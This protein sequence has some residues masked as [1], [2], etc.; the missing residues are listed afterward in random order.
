[1]VLEEAFEEVVEAMNLQESE[2]QL[3]C[4]LG[5]IEHMRRNKAVAIVGPVCSGKTQILK[6]VAQTLKGAFD[7]LFRTSV[8]NPQT[9]TKEEFYG[10]IN[11]FESQSQ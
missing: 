9:Y 4:C 8:V 3:H 10:P 2:R 6:I 1:M 11:A 5:V 7:V